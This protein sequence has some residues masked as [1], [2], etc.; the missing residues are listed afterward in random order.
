METGLG[1]LG[2]RT[3]KTNSFNSSPWTESDVSSSVLAGGG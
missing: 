3:L 1:L 2:A